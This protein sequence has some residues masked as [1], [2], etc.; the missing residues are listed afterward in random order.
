MDDRARNMMLDSI[1]GNIWHAA[2]DSF[3]LLSERL[4]GSQYLQATPPELGYGGSLFADWSL[5]D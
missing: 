2:I 4:K 1:F 5:E 3:N